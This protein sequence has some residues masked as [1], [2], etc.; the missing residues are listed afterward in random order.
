MVIRSCFCCRF[1]ASKCHVD[2]MH[3]LTVRGARG[4]TRLDACENTFECPLA[5]RQTPSSLFPPV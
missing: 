4:N 3:L 2:A 1:R 5:G